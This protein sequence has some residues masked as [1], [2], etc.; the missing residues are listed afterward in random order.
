[1]KF[2]NNILA[3]NRYLNF[4]LIIAIGSVIV[5]EAYLFD[6]PEIVPWGEEFG[7]IYYKLSLSLMASYIFYFIVIHLKSQLDKENINAF[8]ATKSFGVIGDYISQIEALKKEVNFSI[9][10]NY[11]LKKEIE[12]IFKAINPKNNAPLLLGQFGNY[13]NWLQYMSYYKDRTQKLI[14]KIFIKMPFLDSK[15]VRLLAEIDDCSHFVII[16][17]TLNLQFGNNDMSAWA[18][19]FY[20]YSVKCKELDKYNEKNLSQFKPK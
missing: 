15:L 5:M 2:I 9:E 10:E 4:T 6:I 16:E 18:S 17:S 7:A 11:L 13:A 8:V 12:E 1:M 3:V 19:T 20:E 14:Q